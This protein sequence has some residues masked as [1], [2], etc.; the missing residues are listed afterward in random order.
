MPFLPPSHQRQSTE[1]NKQVHYTVY[2]FRTY[3]W[4][5]SISCCLTRGYRMEIS[6]T[7]WPRVSRGRLFT[8]LNDKFIDD[9]FNACNCGFGAGEVWDILLCDSSQLMAS[10]CC[11]CWCYSCT[12]C[13]VILSLWHVKWSSYI[14]S[15]AV[16]VGRSDVLN[17]WNCHSLVFTTY[18]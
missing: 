12:V 2:K 13:V 7:W 4:S 1:G 18:L 9:K 6:A 5:C 16:H 10:V 14:Y 11:R 8:C 3:L 17:V 15:G